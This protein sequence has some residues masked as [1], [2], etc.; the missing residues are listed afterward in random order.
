[1]LADTTFLIDVMKGEERALAKARELEAASTPMIVGT[2]TVFELYVGVGLSV[3]SAEER[4]NVLEVLRSLTQLPL[5]QQSA[6]RGGLIYAQRSREGVEMDPEDAMLAGIA[7]ENHETV[8][9]RNKR[10]FSGI[11]DLKIES[12]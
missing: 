12:Y 5:D 11:H 10:H 4:E 2:P 3:K 8:L 9:T 1:M 6:S 7:V